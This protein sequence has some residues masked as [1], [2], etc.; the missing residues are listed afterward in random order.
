[1]TRRPSFALAVGAVAPDEWQR[2]LAAL[3][4]DLDAAGLTNACTLT[5]AAGR[6]PDVAAGDAVAVDL[7]WT[8]DLTTVFTG[9]VDAV[10]PGLDEVRLHALDG[11]AGLL[12]LR[13]DQAYERVSAGDVV[14]DL[15]GRAGVGVG[16]VEDGVRF[17]SYVVDSRRSAGQH[18]RSLART[19]GFESYCDA[20]NA[21]VFRRFSRTLADHTFA[22]GED[23]LGA[24]LFQAEPA[25]GQVQVDGESPAGSEGEDAWHWLASDWSGYR[26]RAGSGGAAL[27]V[28]DAALRTQAAAQAAAEALLDDL[29]AAAVSGSVTVPGAP[30]VRLGD[31]VAI[32]DAPAGALGAPFRVRRVRHHLT[33]DGGLVTR[34]DFTTLPGAGGAP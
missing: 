18:V 32:R 33:R 8:D 22:Y 7:G 29:R 26:G 14:R 25:V 1:M 10:E 2:A 24:A 16:E 3:R 12:A 30:Q 21:L 13:L 17:P 9:V 19:C 28:R 20:D 31:A 34:I 23:V 27:L 15:A 11:G 5:V 4:I 6:M